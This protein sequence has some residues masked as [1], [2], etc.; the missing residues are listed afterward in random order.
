MGEDLFWAFRGGGGASFGVILAWKINLVVVPS[1]VTVFTISRTLE[2]NA[3]NLVHRWQYIVDKFDDDFF[4]RVFIRIMKSSTQDGGKTTRASLVSLYLD[5]V[6][7]LFPLMQSSFPKLGMSK[8][9]CIE[10][11]WIEST[12][13]F[14]GYS[15]Q[16]SIDVLLDRSQLSG[17]LFQ[18]EV[19]KEPISENGLEDIWERFYEEKENMDEMALSPYGGRMSEISE[20]ETPVPHRVGNIYNIHYVVVWLEK[21]TEASERHMSWIRRLYS[22][23]T[24]FVTKFPR[25]AF[26]NFRDFDIGVDRGGAN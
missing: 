2:Q 26:L 1:I 24:P 8:E 13:Y 17:I 12:L 11:S 7:T 25:S 3:T 23:T 21:R 4:M 9:D 14:A 19:V 20:S 10:M 22:Y 18:R 5:R 15:S 6:D 16:D